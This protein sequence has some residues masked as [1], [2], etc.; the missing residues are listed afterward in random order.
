MKSGF[1]PPQAQLDRFLR[2]KAPGGEKRLVVRHLLAGCPECV[3]AV[4]TFWEL[5]GTFSTEKGRTGG[6]KGV[7][8]R[9]ALS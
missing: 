4:R 5:A 1:H 6:A 2:G 9:Q 7:R 8:R 3:A